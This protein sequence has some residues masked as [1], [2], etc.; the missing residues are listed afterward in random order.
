MT[1]SFDTAFGPAIAMPSKEEIDA[2]KTLG[3]IA[4]IGQLDVFDQFVHSMLWSGEFTLETPR[5]PVVVIKD[6][7]K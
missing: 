2:E 6:T 1:R 4:R 3:A 7:M 5:R